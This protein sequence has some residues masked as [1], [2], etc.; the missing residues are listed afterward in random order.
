MP[1]LLDH[2]DVLL[3]TIGSPQEYQDTILFK[4]VFF[5]EAIVYV[6]AL[7]DE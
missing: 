4:F 2:L 7:N 1:F 6:T 3:D 5:E